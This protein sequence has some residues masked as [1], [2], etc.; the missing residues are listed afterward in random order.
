MLPKSIVVIRY[1]P[2]Y[3]HTQAIVEILELPRN[4]QKFQAILELSDHI[5]AFFQQAAR[6]TQSKAS[7]RLKFNIV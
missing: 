3:I 5:P 2:R 6:Q 1:F 4:F 7:L